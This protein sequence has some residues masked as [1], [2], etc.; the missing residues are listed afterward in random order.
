MNEYK[1]IKVQDKIIRLLCFMILATIILIVGIVLNEFVMEENGNKMPVYSVYKYENN[2][3]FK[4]EYFS[5]QDEKEVNYSFFT[6]RIKTKNK[7][8]SVGDIMFDIGIYLFLVFAVILCVYVFRLY[9]IQNDI[10]YKV[11]N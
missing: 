8:I 10:N 6:D 5:Y 1:I 4:N 9:K 2:D 3:N 11:I 7:I